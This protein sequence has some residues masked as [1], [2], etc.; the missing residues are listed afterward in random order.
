MQKEG[1]CLA[2]RVFRLL[3]MCQ[4]LFPHPLADSLFIKDSATHL[5]LLWAYRLRLSDQSHY[6]YFTRN[7]RFQACD[8][9]RRTQTIDSAPHIAAQTMIRMEDVW[10]ISPIPTKGD[11]IPPKRKPTAPKI[12]EA[13]PDDCRPSSIAKVVEEEKTSLSTPNY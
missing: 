11:T 13:D 5:R 4:M 9:S 8:Q 10:I 7:I 2:V 12:A 3:S 6:S 1:R